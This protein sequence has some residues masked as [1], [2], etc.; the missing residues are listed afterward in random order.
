MKESSLLYGEDSSAIGLD[1]NIGHH[2]MLLY[3]I[4]Y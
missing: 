1:E 2:R 4:D 3:S